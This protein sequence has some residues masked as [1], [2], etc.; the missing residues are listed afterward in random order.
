MEQ[1]LGIVRNPRGCF[2]AGG[3]KRAQK[4]NPQSPRMKLSSRD[5]IFPAWVPRRVFFIRPEG[6]GAAISPGDNR[7][8]ND[9]F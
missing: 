8:L 4:P 1:S 6:K 9:A 5:S 3:I 2:H 7:R